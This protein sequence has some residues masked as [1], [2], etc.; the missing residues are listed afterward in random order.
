M[1]YDA[2]KTAWGEIASSRTSVLCEERY[3]IEMDKHFKTTLLHLTLAILDRS[4]LPITGLG[5]S[6]RTAMVGRVTWPPVSKRN[7]FEVNI[8]IVILT[9]QLLSSALPKFAPDGKHSW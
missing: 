5:S 9:H 3:H 7:F 2:Q 1:V 8:E 6:R 4:H